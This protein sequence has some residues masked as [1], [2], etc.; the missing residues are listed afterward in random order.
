[1]E[2]NGVLITGASGLLGRAL[3][4]VFAAGGFHVYGQYHRE[5]P[6][7]KVPGPGRCEWIQADFS[8]PAGI[9]D[10]LAQCSIDEIPAW[11]RQSCVALKESCAPP[12]PT[13]AGREA[14]PGE[15]GHAAH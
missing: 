12:P 4:E 3:T 13:A 2:D 15:G 5:A 10:F 8:S 6:D 11:L 14:A 9:A 7:V 1:M